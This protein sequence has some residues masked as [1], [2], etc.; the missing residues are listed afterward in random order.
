LSVSSQFCKKPGLIFSVFGKKFETA[1][2]ALIFPALGVSSVWHA[3][4][5]TNENS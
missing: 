5:K 2:A 1:T 3:D 4:C